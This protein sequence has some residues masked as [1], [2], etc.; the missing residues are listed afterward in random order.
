MG[1]K[2]KWQ[3]PTWLFVLCVLFISPVLAGEKQKIIF[4]PPSVVS[5][6]LS[7][8]WW[9][10]G[11]PK[12]TIAQAALLLDG[13]VTASQPSLEPARGQAVCYMLMVDTSMSMKKHFNNKSIQDLLGS[14]I[15]GKPESHYLGV[16]TFAKD[17]KLLSK[18]QQDKE[19]LKASLKQ[20]KPEG[21]RTELL[22]FTLEGIGSLS[23]CPTEAYRK[24]LVILSDGD[25]EDKAYTVEAAVTTARDNHISMYAFGF[26]DSNALQFPRRLA[27][28]SGGRFIEPNE[29]LGQ[30]RESASNMLYTSSN[31]GGQLKASLPKLKADQQVQLQ[32]TLSDGQ[33]L[34]ESLP[35]NTVSGPALP[36]WKKKLLEWL[37]WLTAAQL[38]YILWGLGLLLLLL[39]SW[40][41]YRAFRPQ[42]A[43]TESPRDPIAVLVHQGH[44]Y[45]IY[46]GTN[47]L[48]F[49]PTNDIVVDDTTVS[50]THATLHYQGDGDVVLTDLNSLNGSWINGNRIQHP[51]IVQEGDDLAFG[52]WHVLFQRVNIQ[53]RQEK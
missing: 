33:Q 4:Q 17:W 32:L 36:V 14:L 52:E 15:A 3:L 21:D 49:L 38:G 46:P 39:I 27:E 26:Q 34:T 13:S 18:P 8:Q 25:A 2:S 12:Q 53:G 40:L 48:G 29:H 35:L 23:A 44:S 22:R 16:A 31:S 41:A 6:D 9:V 51:S 37:P 50:R 45:P 10:E 11:L 42:A 43:S 5:D 7:L 19:A 47:S 28:E 20:I 30:K 24:V 1:I